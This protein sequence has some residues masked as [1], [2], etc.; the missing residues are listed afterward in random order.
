METIL[1]SDENISQ[2]NSN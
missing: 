2:Y 1:D